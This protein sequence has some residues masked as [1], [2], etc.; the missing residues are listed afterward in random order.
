MKRNRNVFI[1][2]ICL[3]IAF[4][5]WTALICFVDVRPIGPLSSSIGFA[6]IN[7]FIHNL[8]GT[9]IAIYNITDWL[10]LVPI[11]VCLGFGIL[12][13]IQWFKRKSIRKVDSSILL[14]GGFYILTFAI[15]LFF[16]NVVINYRPILINGYLEAS[17]PSSTTMLT[18]CVM[19]TAFQQFSARIKNIFFK[20]IVLYSIVVFSLFMIV[21][22]LICGVHWF[23]DIVGGAL[24]SAGLVMM[25]YS[26]VVIFDK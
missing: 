16:E 24:L 13:L 4:G 21:G 9:N 20:K 26:L 23:T 15:Y 17:Y 14:L 2:A 1:M 12:G 7:K 11:I 8:T 5:L 25:Y 19:P 22:R 3:F 10:G 6:G 18:L